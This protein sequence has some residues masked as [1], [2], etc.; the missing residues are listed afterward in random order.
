MLNAFDLYR[1]LRH[2]VAYGLDTR[3][4]KKD[5]ENIIEFAEDFLEKVRAYL[6]L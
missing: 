6:K 4:D 3:L 2:A 1:K 5:A